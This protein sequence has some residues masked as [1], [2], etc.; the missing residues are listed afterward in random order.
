MTDLNDNSSAV[1]P[2]Q[3][4]LVA[5]L[6][7]EMDADSAQ[8]VEE[9]LARDADFRQTLNDLERS[10]DLL[11]DLPQPTS[12]DAFTKT[13]VEMVT[14]QLDKDVRQEEAAFSRRKLAGPL[15]AIAAIVLALPIGFFAY[16]YYLEGPN[17][18][19]IEDLPVIQRVEVYQHIDDIEFLETLKAEGL[20]DEPAD[21]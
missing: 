16:R 9:R 8:A 15:L 5:Y 21:Q 19:L 18:Q 7:G 3:E 4:Q 10:W 17:R 14:L 13:T 12:D 6:D 1:D 11:D 20:F 2:D